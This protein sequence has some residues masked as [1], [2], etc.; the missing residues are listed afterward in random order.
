M[1]NDRFRRLLL[2]LP[3]A[4]GAVAALAPWRALAEGFPSKPL[5]M[6]VPFPAGGPTDIVA[7]PFAKLLGDSLGQQ[8]YID[9]RGGA[10]GGIGASSVAASSPDGYTLFM[11]T[12][13]TSAINPALYKKMGYDPVAD[14]TPL[15][16]VASAPVAVVVNP[17]TGINSLADLV[18]KAKAQ[19]DTLTY[20]SAGNGTPGHLAGAMFC[21][22]AGIKLR[23]VPYKG[24]A[25]AVTDLLGGT[26]QVMF[27][28]LQ[29]VLPHVQAG[30]LKILGVTSRQR[31]T[32]VPT[33]PTVA[34]SVI[35]DFEMVAWWAVYGPARMPPHVTTRLVN[36]IQRLTKSP[37][38]ERGLGNMGVQPLNVP[39]AQL[40][41]DETA[42]WGAAVR[43][44]GLTLE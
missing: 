15:A 6:V 36:E 23:H 7:R 44:S 26:I 24:S 18:A 40:Q 28:P 27:D 37:E 25:P 10:G 20:G 3:A 41:R 13:G 31:A 29:S 17:A 1:N 12:V 33:I 21:S 32:A 38:F 11:G 22:G 8:V 39:L 14:F 4:A 5:R 30:K 2:K 16:T 35:P 19:P 43:T 42:K 34:E 9:N